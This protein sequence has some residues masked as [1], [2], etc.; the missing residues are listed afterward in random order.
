MS[1][2]KSDSK[3]RFKIFE[4]PRPNKFYALGCDVAEGIESGDY[5]C[6]CVLDTEGNQVAVWHG[7]AAPDIFGEILCRIGKYYNNALVAV[8]VNNH[9]ISV[10][11]KMRDR[12][13]D[14]VY[15]RQVKDERGEDYTSKIGWHTN[16]K[17]KPLMLDE[18]IGA[19]R[20]DRIVIY[21]HDLL[22]EMTELYL[23]ENGNININ[24]KDRVAAAAIALQALKQLPKE[25]YKASHPDSDK[26][27]KYKTLLERQKIKEK[28]ESYYD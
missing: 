22:V 16:L 25:I 15:M 17:T 26:K 13:Y 24:G 6:A 12:M 14:N 1:G 19:V 2:M 7:H 21:D 11:T 20:D 8:E 23:D 9:G 5:S 3:G 28:K 18:L 27:E 4:H 10:T